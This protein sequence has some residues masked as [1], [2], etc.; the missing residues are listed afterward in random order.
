MV[1]PQGAVTPAYG[2]SESVNSVEAIGRIEQFDPLMWNVDLLRLVRTR[3]RNQHLHA[4][5]PRNYYAP[6]ELVLGALADPRW[7]WRTVKGIARSTKLP[8][9]LIEKIL[10]RNNDQIETGRSESLVPL[11]RLKNRKKPVRH[12]LYNLL[13]LILDTLSLGKRHSVQP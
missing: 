4:D 6:S 8:I 2:S 7:D 1:R 13:N 9:D 10:S 3:V 5:T 12:V 11:F